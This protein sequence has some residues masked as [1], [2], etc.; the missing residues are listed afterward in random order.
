MKVFFFAQQI[1]RREKK[2]GVDEGK[3]KEEAVVLTIRFP[4]R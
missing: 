4:G 3:I 1:D 2:D